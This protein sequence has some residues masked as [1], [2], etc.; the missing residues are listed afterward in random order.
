MPIALPPH[1]TTMPSDVV[2]D[3]A[4]QSLGPAGGSL[5]S[6]YHRA[7][8]ALGMKCVGVNVL[9]VQGD[10]PKGLSALLSR[11]NQGLANSVGTSGGVRF[12]Y[13]HP[14][15]AAYAT[16][17][18]SDRQAMGWLVEQGFL[19]KIPGLSVVETGQGGLTRIVPGDQKQAQ[20][21]LDS[22][23]SRV[24]SSETLPFPNH[25]DPVL[26]RWLALFHEAGHA[27]R[28]LENQ[29]FVAPAAAAG[30][31]KIL[32]ELLMGPTAY[33]SSLSQTFDESYADTFAVLAMLRLTHSSKQ[34]WAVVDY[35]QKTRHDMQK[36]PIE[37]GYDPHA[38]SSALDRL[39]TDLRANPSHQ[40]DLWSAPPARIH[41][42][43]SQYA[44][45]G[46]Q[47]WAQHLPSES[48]A[49]GWTQVVPDPTETS[50]NQAILNDVFFQVQ[51]DKINT[52][53]KARVAAYVNHSPEQVIPVPQ[54]DGDPLLVALSTHDG[55]FRSVF[56]ARTTAHD[57]RVI[58]GLLESPPFGGSGQLII[59][60]AFNE[61]PGVAE[62]KEMIMQITGHYLDQPAN[63]R[64]E[65]DFQTHRGIRAAAVLA[66]Q[67][68][69]YD[70]WRPFAI[71]SAPISRRPRP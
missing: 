60:N 55:N 5:L 7:A 24:M 35:L 19:Q 44:S 46:T 1:Q 58:I 34:A 67:I 28:A 69:G 61:S 32:N 11:H 6:A 49:L 66:Q 42:W 4:R 47:I 59:E 13:A 25:L 9:A 31:V 17:A 39:I 2:G 50:E 41:Q 54:T 51:S 43:A 14:S 63:M 30:S 29:A 52:Y 65:V 8:R 20:I 68:P 64:N 21:S 16:L 40:E 38:S 27:Q 53:L 22:D 45:W 71:A 26:F 56:N 36:H 70:P 10:L 12:V 15:P 3:Q 33:P 48:T 57:H 23:I 18:A 62:V 37:K